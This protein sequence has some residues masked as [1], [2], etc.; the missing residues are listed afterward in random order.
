MPL[1]RRS[2]LYR[3]PFVLLRWND[4]HD[5]SPRQPNFWCLSSVRSSSDTIGDQLA[6]LVDRVPHCPSSE[7][8][9]RTCAP[10]E[11]SRKYV[12]RILGRL[13]AMRLAW[14]RPVCGASLESPC[15]A[16]T[17]T[18][19][20]TASYYKPNCPWPYVHM[21]HPQ[22]CTKFYIC[23]EKPNAFE[24]SFKPGCSTAWTQCAVCTD[25]PQKRA[26]WS[27]D[28]LVERTSD[29][30]QLS[31]LYSIHETFNVLNDIVL[32]TINF[33]LIEFRVLQLVTKSSSA[34]FWSWPNRL[35]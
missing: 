18:L 33:Y 17:A 22:T 29:L 25:G 35:V 32:N 30:M 19:G 13:R 27:L 14:V 6:D 4:T 11:L 16:I 12:S 5:M 24:S 26:W 20:P 9:S 7:T 21:P 15:D 10:G 3:W 28:A 31:Q 23:D 2:H 34:H 8:L 1:P